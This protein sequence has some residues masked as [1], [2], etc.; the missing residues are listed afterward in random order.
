MP[1]HII[2]YVEK[3]VEVPQVVYEERIIEVPEVHSV[4]AITEVPKPVVQQVEKKIP[5]IQ[6]LRLLESP[7]TWRKTCFSRAL[8]CRKL[9][10]L[11]GLFNEHFTGFRMFL[12][13]HVVFELSRVDSRSYTGS[14]GVN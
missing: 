6:T 4:E 7:R 8:R 10:F 13:Q 9:W 1:K 11:I 5:K 3:I 12:E 14:Q 2:E